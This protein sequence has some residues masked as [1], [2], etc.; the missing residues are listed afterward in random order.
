MK[1]MEI[2]TLIQLLAKSGIVLHKHG[3]DIAVSGSGPRPSKDHPMWKLVRLHLD[4]I[5]SHFGVSRM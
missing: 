4:E 5:C 2:N 3:D 1:K